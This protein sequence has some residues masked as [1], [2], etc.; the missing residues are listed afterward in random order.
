MSFKQYLKAEVSLLRIQPL[1]GMKDSLCC[2][3]VLDQV[4]KLGSG[5]R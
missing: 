4:L 5:S 3:S 2:P 1:L